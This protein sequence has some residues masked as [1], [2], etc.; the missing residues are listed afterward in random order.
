LTPETLSSRWGAHGRA[1]QQ[2]KPEREGEGG[3]EKG[4]RRKEQTYDSGICI[5]LISSNNADLV[6]E[7]RWGGE[8]KG[9]G[10]GK[11]KGGRWWAAASPVVGLVAV[12]MARRRREEGEERRREKE[13]KGR[14]R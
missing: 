13:E 8:K 10:K 14:K 12:P 3:K 9:K 1:R 4:R 5:F 6:K 11:K 7:G 2:E